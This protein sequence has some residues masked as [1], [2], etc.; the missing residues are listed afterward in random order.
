MNWPFAHSDSHDQ[1]ACTAGHHTGE[2]TLFEV[3]LVNLSV[4]VDVSH[5]NVHVYV[6][7]TGVVVMATVVSGEVT[8]GFGV[9]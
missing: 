9:V 1:V 6:E 8:P 5:V 3:K 2:V 4:K 7:L